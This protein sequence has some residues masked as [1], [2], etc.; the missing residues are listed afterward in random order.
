[1]LT[2]SLYIF[3]QDTL[4]V[5]ERFEQHEHQPTESIYQYVKWDTTNGKLIATCKILDH[6]ILDQHNNV[7]YHR[8][9][10]YV[11]NN[12]HWTGYLTLTTNKNHV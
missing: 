9:I 4:G 7:L 8:E 11:C 10:Q 12:Q 2:A 6:M 3:E 5:D 1:M